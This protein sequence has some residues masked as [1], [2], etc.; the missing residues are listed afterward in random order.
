M[1]KPITIQ[2]IYNEIARLDPNLT[3]GSDVFKAAVVMLSALSIGQD[4]GK[5]SK[6]TG[7]PRAVIAPFAANLRKNKIWKDGETQADWFKRGEGVIAFFLDLN[8]AT[9]HMGRSKAA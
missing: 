8:V 2:F 7:L 9:G 5:L 1:K 3:I 6:F 4:I